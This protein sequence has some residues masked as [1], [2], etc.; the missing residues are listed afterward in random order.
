LRSYLLG[1]R[2]HCSPVSI[3]FCTV[4]IR[5]MREAYGVEVG[6]ALSPNDVL[7]AQMI[8]SIRAMET[9]AR[10]RDLTMS[11]NLRP[12]CGLSSSLLG[13]IT[14]VLKLHCPSTES[15]ARLAARIRHAMDNFSEEHL[16]VGA[17]LAFAEGLTPDQRERL[18]C[19]DWDPLG[20]GVFLTNWSRSGAYDCRF[21]G[22]APTYA[23]VA[24]RQVPTPWRGNIVEG[25]GNQGTLV[26]LWLP[27]PLVEG[28]ASAG[29][30]AHLHRFRRA[31]DPIPELSRGLPAV[32]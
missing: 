4:E 5:R 18:D 24:S 27:T 31:E 6:Q 7:C 17:N 23:G 12:R 1:A 20:Q 30:L 16:D 26:N 11:V 28:L 32:L 8:D 21:H 25:F 14:T 22:H 19:G 9:T 2:Q 10:N 15:P 13:N 29:G 3:Y